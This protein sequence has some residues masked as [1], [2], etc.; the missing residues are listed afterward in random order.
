[1]LLRNFIAIAMQSLIW[2]SLA[3]ASEWTV[4]DL[5]LHEQAQAWAISR[6]ASMAAFVKS[7]VTKVEG[8]EQRVSNLWLARLDREDTRALT[9]GNKQVSAP[10][11]SPDGKHIAFISDRELP[12]D[13]G[14]SDSTEGKKQLW[15]ISTDGGEAWPL[16]A[17]DQ[18]V[19]ALDWRDPQHLIAVAAESLSRSPSAIVPFGA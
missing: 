13:A 18:D 12:E 7:T 2:V 1:M 8:E 9:R 16:T 5:V 17:F 4:D 15:L 3:S 14:K 19:L 11:F 6:D 10:S